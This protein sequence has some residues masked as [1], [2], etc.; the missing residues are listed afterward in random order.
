M[1]LPATAQRFRV[2]DAWQ[3]VYQQLPTLPSENQYIAVETKQPDRKNTFVGRLISYH[4]Y[5][6]GRPKSLRLDWKHTIADYLGANEAIDEVT[7]P[8][9]KRLRT[10]PLEGDRAVLQNLTRAERDQLIQVLI[11]TLSARRQPPAKSQPVRVQPSP[12]PVMPVIP[13]TAPQPGGADLLR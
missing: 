11:E 3:L 1:G 13:P 2:G 5:V 4:L 10:N 6:K 9:Q 7:Y 8:T 12:R